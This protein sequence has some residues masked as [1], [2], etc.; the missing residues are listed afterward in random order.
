[1][2]TH[3]DLEEQEQLDQIKHYWKQ[4][5]NAVT[6]VLIV[7]LGAYAAWSGFQYWQRSQAA[8]AAV[9][10]DEMERAAQAQDVQKAERILEDLRGKYA[11]TTY[12][13]QGG[14]LA[15]RVMLDKNNVDGARAALNWVAEQTGDDGLKSLAR[16]RLAALQI[17][18][19]TYDEALKTLSSLKAWLR[20]ARAMCLPCKARRMRPRLNTRRPIKSWMSELSTAVWCK[21]SS[22]RWGWMWPL[23]PM[24]EVRSDGGAGS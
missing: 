24:L 9:L 14:L 12:A 23:P 3:L 22:T 20:I 19:K 16:L 7:A 10:Y 15:A 13:Q 5:G 17:D 21:S 18:A 6:W 2:A 8:H 4:Y 1:M 11:R